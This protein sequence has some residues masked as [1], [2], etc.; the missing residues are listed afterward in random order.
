MTTASGRTAQEV[1]RHHSQAMIAGD[2]DAI[3][4]D[5]A[6]DARFIT[7][8]GVLHGR[9]GVRE[10]FLRIFADLP[11]PRFEVTTRILEGDVMFLEWKAA[12][13]GSRADD[14]VETFVVHDGEIVL[15]TVHYT[16]RST[17]ISS[18]GRAP[19]G[20]AGRRAPGA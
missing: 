8:A 20:P 14:G 15:Q 1:F 3:V 13:N 17:W 11:D 16:P 6:D 12:A 2:L 19:A 10:G 4:S 18:R 7:P 5:Y 9:T